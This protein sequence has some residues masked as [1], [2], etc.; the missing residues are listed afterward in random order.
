MRLTV[1][2]YRRHYTTLSQ[3]LFLLLTLLLLST[4]PLPRLPMPLTFCP[5]CPC[6]PCVRRCELQLGHL[7]EA[8]QWVQVEVPASFQSIVNDMVAHCREL[9]EAGLNR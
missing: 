1:L 5:F 4:L 3:L 8:E 6:S 2:L 9:Q 7:L